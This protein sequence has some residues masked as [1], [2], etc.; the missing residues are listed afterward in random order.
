MV[1][2][3]KKIQRYVFLNKET[4]FCSSSKTNCRTKQRFRIYDIYVLVIVKKVFYGT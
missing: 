3:E 4:Y 2:V 1:K